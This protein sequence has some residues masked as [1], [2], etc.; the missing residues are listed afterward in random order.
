MTRRAS[1]PPQADL[2]LISDRFLLRLTCAAILLIAITLAISIGGRWLGQHMALGGHSESGTILDVTIGED[3]LQIP[4]NTIRFAEQRHSGP[5]ERVDLYLTWPGMMGYTHERRESFDTIENPDLL[6]FLQISQ[7]TMSKD[8]SGRLV[9]IYSKLFDGPP[10]EFGHGLTL[11]HLK[12]TS[13]YGSEV[14]LTAERPDQQPFAVRCILPSQKNRASS[15]DCQRD[16]HIGSDLTVLYRF[17]STLLQDWNHIDAAV[18]SFVSA[19]INAG[20]ASRAPKG[21]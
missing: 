10:V 13:G 8:M 17:S 15:G 1:A 3:T 2:P 4:E 16:I 20:S 19:R 5:A 21:D 12:N 14:L 7:S 18:R 6:L 9:P 11:H